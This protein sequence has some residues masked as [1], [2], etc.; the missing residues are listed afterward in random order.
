MP[1][2]ERVVIKFDAEALDYFATSSA[3]REDLQ[4]TEKAVEQ[5]NLRIAQSQEKL[6]AEAQSVLR[7]Q[8]EWADALSRSL[9]AQRIAMLELENIRLDALQLNNDILEQQ[10][11]LN[12]LAADRLAIEKERLAVYQEQAKVVQQSVEASHN[13]DQTFARRGGLSA[14]QA[15]GE[16]VN[17]DELDRSARRSFDSTSRL[18]E[19][20]DSV[21]ETIDH[22]ADSIARLDRAIYDSNTTLEEMDSLLEQVRQ[23]R[24]YEIEVINQAQVERIK[25]FRAGLDLASRSLRNMLYATTQ[26]SLA[27]LRLYVILGLIALL[28]VAFET[29]AGILGVV[30][31][32][33]GAFA[34]IRYLEGLRAMRSEL[35]LST[36][37]SQRLIAANR[38]VGLSLEDTHAGLLAIREGLRVGITD[39]TSRE[40]AE[41]DRLGISL[42]EADL[43]GDRFLNTVLALDEALSG[44]AESDAV[45]RINALTDGNR[46]AEQLFRRGNLTERYA[47][48][49]QLRTLTLEE[50]VRID[51]IQ[52]RFGQAFSEFYARMLKFIADNGVA[53][54]AIIDQV[55]RFLLPITDVVANFLTSYIT[56]LNTN[57]PAIITALEN[58]WPHVVETLDQIVLRMQQFASLFTSLGLSGPQVVDVLALLIAINLLAAVLAPLSSLFRSVA[59]LFRGILDVMRG[60]PAVMGRLVDR[61]ANF[62]ARII[63]VASRVAAQAPG[64][65]SAV[66]PAA[67][68]ALIGAGVGGAIYS[69]GSLLVT[70]FR[71]I[72]ERVERE[73]ENARI[74]SAERE[75]AERVRPQAE[76][77]SRFR[78]FLSA[79]LDFVSNLFSVSRAEAAVQPSVVA[80]TVEALRREEGFRGQPYPDA[81]GRSVG[82]GTFLPLSEEELAALSRGRYGASLG[83]QVLSLGDLLPLQRQEA[84][85][86]LR[87]RLNAYISDLERAAAEEKGVDV[88][89]LPQ[90]VQ[91]ALFQMVYQ[92]GVRGLLDFDR[93]WLHIQAREFSAAAAEALNSQWAREDSPARALRVADLFRQ[94]REGLAAELDTISTEEF[95]RRVASFLQR[96]TPP[97]PFVAPPADAL[98]PPSQQQQPFAEQL[99]LEQLQARLAAESRSFWELQFE[100][101]REAVEIERRIFEQRRDRAA[102]ILAGLRDDSDSG[103]LFRRPDV[104]VLQSDEGYLETLHALS[105]RLETLLFGQPFFDIIREYSSGIIDRI[106]DTIA[107]DLAQITRAFEI[108]SR[109]FIDG[110]IAYAFDLV[111]YIQESGFWR[112]ANAIFGPG[113]AAIPEGIDFIS[114]QF[115]RIRSFFS[116]LFGLQEEIQGNRLDFLGDVYEAAKD[117]INFALFRDI[118]PNILNTAYERL[119]GLEEEILKPDEQIAQDV[120]RGRVESQGIRTLD[121][122]L[123]RSGFDRQQVEDLIRR[124]EEE[125]RQAALSGR[126]SPEFALEIQE[127]A[128]TY[129]FKN[130]ITTLVELIQADNEQ[131]EKLRQ[132]TNQRFQRAF[133][134]SQNIRTFEDLL[135]I[136]GKTRPEV[137]DFIRRGLLEAEAARQPGGSVSADFVREEQEYINQHGVNLQAIIALQNQE[138][139]ERE[140]EL[141]RQRRAAE[142][143][144]ERIT[145]AE[146]SRR[147]RESEENERLRHASLQIETFS[148]LVNRL[149]G[150]LGLP[151]LEGGTLS[152][153]FLAQRL[154]EIVRAGANLTEEQRAFIRQ[155]RDETGLSP[156]DAVRLAQQ[157]RA[158]I[159]L[160]GPFGQQQ[161]ADID[162][163]RRQVAAAEA[164][165]LE[166]ENMAS[167]R[168]RNAELA[169]LAAESMRSFNQTIA[170]VLLGFTDFDDAFKNYFRNLGRDVVTLLL[171]E[172]SRPLFEQLEAF[173][174]RPL[175]RDSDGNLTTELINRALPGIIEAG[176]SPSGK[177]V[178]PVIEQNNYI[179]SDNPNQVASAVR[180]GGREALREGLAT[181]GGRELVRQAIEEEED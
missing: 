98:L 71:R 40:A 97:P 44:L 51:R 176:L 157:A 30:A 119:R 171:N 46:Q 28:V 47:A 25:L 38:G 111:V 166:E 11:T 15:A 12:Q 181:A 23:A 94:G 163:A 162:R 56:R 93:T 113:L 4:E 153:E 149:R 122:F 173:G 100:G 117:F 180:V 165:R 68:L 29:L 159:P 106:V 89:T 108:I 88:T 144:A 78:E 16:Q 52:E 127:L 82:F 19:I 20:L 58:A 145:R 63:P 151:G 140:R 27:L 118:D 83:G 128:R 21:P 124:A 54:A 74:R 96:T 178:A 49:E 161:Q 53:I 55:E 107:N 43:V 69:V 18:K 42:T 147:Q 35:N 101:M 41:L 26:L 172:V 7:R 48:T 73:L 155:I 138:Q 62:S 103:D 75:L 64:V 170:D 135:T 152:G 45:S 6:S 81:G 70:G 90:N 99:Q 130:P 142:R 174:Q 141:A 36:E 50:E 158:P 9:E 37:A 22:Q 179:Y 1:A 87:S 14:G 132:Q 137:E 59:F 134:E 105:Q 84:E 115:S 143:E 8:Q 139:E 175:A 154:D 65:A 10:H 92:L 169:S 91:N 79:S 76:E 133:V 67:R 2:R 164:L 86:I 34:S 146:E 17:F 131:I 177:R 57:I 60:L 156:A 24:D 136:S 95:N 129:G 116:E 150:P 110:F 3:V 126:F 168:A 85:V 102:Q 121:D 31:I 148:E 32:S 104:S 120:E 123:Q 109:W 160:A 66:A 39:R 112:L 80:A 61:L 5:T 13:L 72:S 77:P 33:F 114:E 125:A 167:E